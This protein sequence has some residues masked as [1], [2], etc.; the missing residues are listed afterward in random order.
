MSEAGTAGSEFDGGGFARRVLRAL[1]WAAGAAILGAG[2]AALV[3]ARVPPTWQA[4][5][6]LHLLAPRAPLPDGVTWPTQPGEVQALL[7]GAAIREEVAKDPEARAA[8]E[9][10]EGPTGEARYAKE[11]ARRVSVYP[12][13]GGRAVWVVVRDADAARAARLAARV[14]G[15]GAALSR[16]SLLASVDRL[17]TSLDRAASGHREEIRRLDSELGQLGETGRGRVG[18]LFPAEAEQLLAARR[19]RVNALEEIER[20]RLAVR[21]LVDGGSSPW[22]VEPRPGQGGNLVPR[23][24]FAQLAG[25]AL[26]AAALAFLVRLLRD[27]RPRRG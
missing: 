23:D 15:A 26:F 4:S 9:A 7:L 11:Y 16:A 21:E 24:R 19:V 2:V 5:L 17:T 13:P 3:Y 27:G 18:G 6:H 8:F 22:S 12:G 1:A 10:G 20:Q 14:A 25:P